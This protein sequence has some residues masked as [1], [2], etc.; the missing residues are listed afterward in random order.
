MRK[1]APSSLWDFVNQFKLSRQAAV[2]NPASDSAKLFCGRRRRCGDCE[3]QWRNEGLRRPGAKTMKCA[4]PSREKEHPRNYAGRTGPE[5]KTT[6]HTDT[7]RGAILTCAQKLT[8]VSLIY[9]TEPKTKKRKKEK[10][11]SKNG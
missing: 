2:K 8:Q 1:L 10:L 3:I 11:K 5:S 9:R 4:T 6:E 7:I